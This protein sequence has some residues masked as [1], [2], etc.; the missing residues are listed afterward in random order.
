MIAETNKMAWCRIT[1]TSDRNSIVMSLRQRVLTVLV[2]VG[3]EVHPGEVGMVEVRAELDVE[4]EVEVEVEE[5]V[6]VE[7]V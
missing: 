5:Q 1:P 3:E 2:G 7:V 6:E 4:A